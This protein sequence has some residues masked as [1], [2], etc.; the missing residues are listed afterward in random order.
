VVGQY[1]VGSSACDWQPGQTGQTRAVGGRLTTGSAPRPLFQQGT[2]TMRRYGWLT[3]FFLASAGSASASSWAEGL[4]DD[5]SRD[6]GSVA[7]GPILSHPFRLVN[8]TK[9][10][11]HIAGLR[12]SCS[13]CTTARALQTTLAPGQETAI[14]VQM[15]TRRFSNYKTVTVYVTFDQP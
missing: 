7:R 6:F 1:Q 5:L 15:D 3:I 14:V 2:D 13:A 12:V 10:T 11:V 8:N 4:F 9:Q